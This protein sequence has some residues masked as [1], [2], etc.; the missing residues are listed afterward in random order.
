MPTENNNDSANAD[1]FSN[2]RN[3]VNSMLEEIE[4]SRILFERSSD[5]ITPEE[6]TELRKKIRYMRDVLIP[7]V[8]YIINVTTDVGKEE[9]GTNDECFQRALRS[10]SPASVVHAERGLS[11]KTEI[12]GVEGNRCIYDISTEIDNT[13]LN[14]VCKDSKY[15]LGIINAE[16]FREICEGTLLEKVYSF[17]GIELEA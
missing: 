7:D 1:K 16:R 15:S 5:Q 4:A 6:L 14:M 3:M 10:C 9:C 11:L 8:L 13:P 17:A 2:A 12:A